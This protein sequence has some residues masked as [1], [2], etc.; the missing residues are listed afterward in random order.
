MTGIRSCNAATT[1]LA[2]VVRMAQVSMSC[3]SGDRHASQT[4]AKRHD[5][6]VLHVNVVGNL[7]GITLLPFIEPAGRQDAAP[8]PER[9]AKRRLVADRFG[10]GID[11][12]A[13]HL[14]CPERHQPPAQQVYP[15]RSVFILE[16]DGDLLGWHHLVARRKFRRYW[17]SEEFGDP[18]RRDVDDVASTHA[19]SLSRLTLENLGAPQGEAEARRNWPNRALARSTYRVPAALSRH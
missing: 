10:A 2:T 5:R 15:P 17:Q 12:A 1:G 4:P 6:S 8:L 13:G 14:F 19:D 18:F 9:L 11:Q 7:P 3:P 16:H